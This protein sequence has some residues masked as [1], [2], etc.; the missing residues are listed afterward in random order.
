MVGLAVLPAATR[1]D[2]RPLRLRTTPTPQGSTDLLHLILVQL[3]I[4]RTLLRRRIIVS[5]S[6]LRQRIELDSLMEGGRDTTL[7]SRRRVIRRQR[8]S[9]R[10]G[11]VIHRERGT[12]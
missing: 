3:E 12:R 1:P 4:L 7:R 8:Q 9:R 10:D 11:H 5:I 6:S 2:N